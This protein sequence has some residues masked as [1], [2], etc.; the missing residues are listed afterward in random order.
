MGYSQLNV[1]LKIVNEIIGISLAFYPN[2]IKVPVPIPEKNCLG[3]IKNL[4]KWLGDEVYL[5]DAQLNLQLIEYP[6]CFETL[7]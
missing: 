3:Q 4:L 2:Q 1:L 5:P 6:L 7:E